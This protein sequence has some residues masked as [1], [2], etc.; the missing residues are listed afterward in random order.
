MKGWL[1]VRSVAASL[2][3]SAALILFPACDSSGGTD[4][5][6]STTTPPPA[7]KWSALGSGVGVFG[8]PDEYVQAL[9]LD[10]DG[11]LYAGGDFSVAGG[12]ATTTVAKWN[13]SV[14]SALGGGICPS[15]SDWVEDMFVDAAGNVYAGGDL[16]F[17]LPA[18]CGLV[19]WDGSSWA[20]LG[21]YPDDVGSVEGLTLDP[22][23]HL[24]A[25]FRQE[26]GGTTSRGLVAEW[27][28]SDWAATTVDAEK[29]NVYAWAI[30]FDKDGNLYAG[31]EFDSNGT[32]TVALNYVAKRANGSSLWS[33]VGAGFNNE[34][35]ALVCDDSGN[36][37]AGGEFTADSTFTT[38][39]NY[40]AKWNGTEWLPLGDGLNGEVHA[41][42][43][44][45]EGNLYAGGFFSGGVA[46]WT[47]SEWETV[48]DGVTGVVL[49]L[50][51]DSDGAL[52]VGGMFS[53]A[54][55]VNAIN[56]AKW[57]K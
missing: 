6:D 55:T 8:D 34:V 17:D 53:K 57:S 38:G 42:A 12:I 25:S 41:L 10:A 28:G 33:A 20:D 27:D 21:P 4:E 46:R 19:K 49:A 54:G 52:Y 22:A 37:Y 18:S 11:N 14:W 48:G 36:L 51:A 56:V 35:N 5:E 30:I 3:L 29:L 50:A 44:D 13:G 23:G 16:E 7:Y 45:S 47:G 1:L 26:V 2:I 43:I 24:H 9:A 31:G 39:F 32:D 40:V 15:G